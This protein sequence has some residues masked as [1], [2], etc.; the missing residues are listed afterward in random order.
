ME[1]E[2]L[3]VQGF[4]WFMRFECLCALN[5]SAGYYIGHYRQSSLPQRQFA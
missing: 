3:M 4:L 5:I 1:V 2:T